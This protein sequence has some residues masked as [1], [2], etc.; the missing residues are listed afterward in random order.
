VPIEKTRIDPNGVIAVLGGVVVGEEAFRFSVD[1]AT[2]EIGQCAGEK[3]RHSSIRPNLLRIM[4]ALVE[5]CFTIAG[6]K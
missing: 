4:E 2:F 3:A 6:S 5:K 1:A